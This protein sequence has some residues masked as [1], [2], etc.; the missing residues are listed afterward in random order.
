MFSWLQRPLHRPMVSAELDLGDVVFGPHPG[1]RRPTAFGDR[2]IELDNI[3]KAY[4]TNSGKNV[5][6]DAISFSFPAH[7]NVGILG[8]NGSGKS[9]LLRVLAGTEE[10]DS[11][12]VR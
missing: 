7:T 12:T 2:V 1:A 4:A 11:G 10:A 6:L 5:V 9:T 8:R 3:T